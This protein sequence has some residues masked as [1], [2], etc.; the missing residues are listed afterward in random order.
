MKSTL[1]Q[2]LEKIFGSEN[3][4]L[5]TDYVHREIDKQFVEDNPGKVRGSIRISAGLFLSNQ[6]R[7]EWRQQVLK[8]KLP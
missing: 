8:S 1:I 7:E 4:I 3:A 2:P 5:E 6:E